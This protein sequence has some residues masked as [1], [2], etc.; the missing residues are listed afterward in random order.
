MVKWLNSPF[1]N[2]LSFWD[3]RYF[4]MVSEQEIL[5]SIPNLTLPPIKIFKFPLIG[6]PL[7]KGKV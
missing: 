1:P 7:I 3:N 6:P 5:S 4:N 2:S